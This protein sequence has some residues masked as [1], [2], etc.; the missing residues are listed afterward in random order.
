MR[1][2]VAATVFALGAHV[3]VALALTLTSPDIQ[4]GGRISGEQAFDGGDCP[5]RNVSPAL[6]WSDVPEGTR[7]FA[8]SM[9]DPDTPPAG[10]FWHWWVYDIP[11]DAIGLRKDAGS[12]AGLPVGASQGRND[13]GQ[14]GYSGPCPPRGS[15]TII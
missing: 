11:A 12:G 7:S 6:S 13:F 1:V 15:R 3:G 10:G 14:V 9:I 8:L 2:L 4:P 5:G